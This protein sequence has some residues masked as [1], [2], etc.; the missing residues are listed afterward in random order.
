MKNLRKDPVDKIQADSR[1]LLKNVMLESNFLRKL[2]NILVK[3]IS[4]ERFLGRF[5]NMASEPI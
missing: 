4:A 5:F 2:R 1:R 3:R